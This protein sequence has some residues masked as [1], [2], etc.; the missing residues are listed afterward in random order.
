MFPEKWEK[1]VNRR[2]EVPVAD[3]NWDEKMVE[4]A[5]RGDDDAAEALLQK[6]KTVVK[7][8]ASSYYMAGAD[9]D[10]VIQEGMIGVFKAIRDYDPEKGASFSTFADLCIN[11]Q[12]VTA[13][14]A[15]QRYK[16]S[17]LNNS[18]SLSNSF[19]ENGEEGNTLEDTI[20]SNASEDPEAMLLLR[21]GLDY[22][23]RN[24]GELLTLL[25]ARSGNSIS[26]ESLTRRLRRSR[27]RLQKPWTTLSPGRSGS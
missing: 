27:E 16:H 5:R 17:P 10:D 11:R 23:G 24:G 22:I 4:L 19:S 26:K 25:K 15:A 14:K 18:M 2:Q 6:Y 21:E 12:I 8:R 3:K 1:I 20:V 13:V 7:R 9:R